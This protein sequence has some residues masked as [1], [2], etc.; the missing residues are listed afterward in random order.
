MTFSNI[1]RCALGASLVLLLA[2]GPSTE[3]WFKEVQIKWR[4]SKS[5]CSGLA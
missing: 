3:M 2:T 5:S 1:V 4:L